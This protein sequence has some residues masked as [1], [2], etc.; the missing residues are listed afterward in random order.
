MAILNFIINVLWWMFI[1][2]LMNIWVVSTLWLLRVM[3][4]STFTYK[5]LCGHIFSF[6]LV[7]FLLVELLAITAILCFMSWKTAKLFSKG[8]TAS[9]IP[10]SNVQR[11]QFLHGTSVLNDQLSW[12]SRLLLDSWPLSESLPTYSCSSTSVPPCSL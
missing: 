6:L 12:I 8:V 5:L 4:L 3:L 9:Y 2:Q 11:L 1:H 10:T 7:R